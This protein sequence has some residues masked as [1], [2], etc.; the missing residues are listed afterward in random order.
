MVILNIEQ[1]T[2]EEYNEH[3]NSP[4]LQE[5]VKVV[6]MEI[7]RD[8]YLRQLIEAQDND[9]IKVITGIRRCGKTY[10][11]LKIFYDYLLGSGI[12]EDH[13]ISIPLDDRR[14]AELRNPDKMLDYVGE[15]RKDR[16]KYYL[17]IDEVQ[18]L[19]DF[20][21]VLNSFLHEEN[22]EV[23][24]TGSNARFLSSDII[25]EFRGRS[26]EIRVYPLSFSE[27]FS[28]YKGDKRDAWDEYVRFG[29]LPQVTLMPSEQ[30]KSAFLESVFENTYERDILERHTIRNKKQF[31]EV[32]ETVA[33]CI[34][35]L[36]STRK[37]ENTFKS[38][39]GKTITKNTI[40]KYLGYLQDAFLIDRAV[41]YDIKGKKYIGSPVKYYF[42]DI[43]VRNAVT[44]FRQLEETHIMENVIFNELKM[45]GCKVD[46][47]SVE[48]SEQNSK[49]DSIRKR[50]EVDFVV[51]RADR[52][53]YI[54]SAL[55]MD[56]R[57]KTMQEEKSLLHT[58]DSFRKI[59]IV[60]G[61]QKPWYTDEGI[62]IIGL[63][64]FLLDPTLIERG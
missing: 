9:L 26:D 14:N 42:T 49:G 44:G 16:G 47:G 63:L 43:G 40:E 58:G 8:Y 7:K 5:K 20:E 35:T 57:E 48:I 3:I 45:L 1:P 18:L 21:S 61:T 60:G 52:R 54:Q 64:N 34:G 62:Q 12:Q 53:Y 39:S 55:R 10:L 33:S 41:R 32:T 51:N 46:V 22:L 24:V 23:Y 11:L 25:T 28:V 2:L 4:I 36:V 30:R 6:I 56:T 17:F 37:L 15:K 27:F 31:R 50:N 13:I 19:N 59:V 29:G 38:S